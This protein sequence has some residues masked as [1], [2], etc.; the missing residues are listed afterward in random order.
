M[1]PSELTL[2][3]YSARHRV[4][5][6]S[7]DGR[8]RWHVAAGAV[9]AVAALALTVAILAGVLIAVGYLLTGTAGAAGGCGGG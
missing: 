8:P 3:M 7:D 2:A 9:R 1:M 4:A 6:Q 5:L